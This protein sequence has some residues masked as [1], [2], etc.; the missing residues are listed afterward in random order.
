MREGLKRR[1]QGNTPAT[2]S[3]IKKEYI[4]KNTINKTRYKVML[5]VFVCIT[6]IKI[7]FLLKYNPSQVKKVLSTLCVPIFM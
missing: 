3:L 1:I 5:S 6:D 2:L 7:H 4:Y